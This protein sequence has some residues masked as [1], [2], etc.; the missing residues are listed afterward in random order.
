LKTNSNLE[1]TKPWLWLASVALCFS[2]LLA[3]MLVLSR[4]PGVQDYFGLI[5]FF[6][7][8]LVLHVNF[9]VL[10]WLLSFVS[11]VWMFKSNLQNS[12]LN[13]LLIGFSVLGTLMMLSSPFFGQA[14]PIMSNYVP[15]LESPLF[16]AGLITFSLGITGLAWLVI[17]NRDWDLVKWSALMWF[18]SLIVLIF[19]SFQIQTK[20]SAT[21]FEALFWGAGHVVQFVY[22]LI[23]WSIWQWPRSEVSRFTHYSFIMILLSVLGISLLFEAGTSVSREAFTSLMRW[24]MILILIPMLW[25]FI[26]NYREVG[27]SV[28]ASALLMVLGMVIGLLIKND[29]VIV[30]AHYHAT[31]AAVTIAFMGLAYRLMNEYCY[32]L[33]SSKMITTQIIMYSVGMLLYVLGMAG[34]G[35]LGVPRKTAVTVDDSLQTISMGIMGLGGAIS[36]IATLLFIAIVLFSLINYK[37]INHKKTLKKLGHQKLAEEWK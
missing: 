19:H 30:T 12:S 26:Q 14:K 9:A 23:L 15:V 22:V 24:G 10:V 29:T 32:C 18:V 16:F 34:S 7:T 25:W 28:K 37:K 6:H 35:W 31:N 3:I 20:D 33:Q 17:R 8:I 4:A 2:A 11:F 36:I 21:Y 5:D 27:L 1:A 13:K